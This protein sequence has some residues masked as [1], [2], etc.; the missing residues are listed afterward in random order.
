MEYETSGVLV[1]E[2]HIFVMILG[3]QLSRQ[4]VDN[5][6]T[7]SVFKWYSIAIV[8]DNS[9]FLRSAGYERGLCPIDN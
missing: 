5:P 4:A 6:E 1:D 8:R 9:L 2:T 7:T 3:E